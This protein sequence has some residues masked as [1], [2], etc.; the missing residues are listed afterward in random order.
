MKNLPPSNAVLLFFGCLLFVVEPLWAQSD[1][2][3]KLIE[4]AKKEGEVIVYGTMALADVNQLNA[5][6]REKYPFVDVKLNRFVPARSS[7]ASLPR[8]GPTNTSPI[9]CRPT[10]WDCIS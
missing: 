3:A 6:F 7:R 1:Q 5:K 4:G 10:A 2:T 8:S 9:F